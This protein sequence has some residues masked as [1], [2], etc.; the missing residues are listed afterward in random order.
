MMLK[1]E[2]PEHTLSTIG[3]SLIETY[4]IK[5]LRDTKE[6]RFYSKKGFHEAGAEE[7]YRADSTGTNQP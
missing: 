6:M 1:E 7:D 5:T 2:K 4:K 3:D